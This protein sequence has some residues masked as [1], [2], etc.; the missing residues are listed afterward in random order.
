MQYNP[1][2]SF[3]VP[4]QPSFFFREGQVQ[5]DVCVWN[6]L[7]KK[8]LGCFF[9]FNTGPKDELIE[10]L[11]DNCFS[12]YF[13]LND[14]PQGYVA[15]PNQALK[16]LILP[17]NATIFI[18]K[19]LSIIKTVLSASFTLNNFNSLYP[20][21]FFFKNSSI[22]DELTVAAD[23]AER[24]RIFLAEARRHIL[25]PK[26]DASKYGFNL[27]DES[28][29]II[30]QSRGQKQVGY[31]AKKMGFSERYCHMLFNDALGLSMK[32]YSEVIRFQNVI[33]MF[34][35]QTTNFLEVAMANNFHDQAHLNHFFKKFTPYTPS[36]YLRI[37]YNY[38]TFGLPIDVVQRGYQNS[39]E[40]Y[41]YQRQTD[42]I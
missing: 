6:P 2:D 22:L 9:E 32:Q 39:P 4:E 25:A 17:A 36:E 21:K 10:L 42:Q 23:F 13:F 37:F 27:V 5:A 29:L 41:R 18:F 40:P 15:G 14:N 35:H 26:Y 1:F 31:I 3:L 20:I 8:N 28:Q 33:K 24:K 7:V 12:F 34:F 30:C 38:E 11:P 16:K 19:P